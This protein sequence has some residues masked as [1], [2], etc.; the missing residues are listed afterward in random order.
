MF[1]NAFPLNASVPLKEK[2]S[3]RLPKLDLFCPSYLSLRLFL[4]F[5]FL[6]FST[7]F[8]SLSLSLFLSSIVLFSMMV[9]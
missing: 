6:F 8:A 9:F 1:Q 4:F 3:R 2:A 5:S 7:F